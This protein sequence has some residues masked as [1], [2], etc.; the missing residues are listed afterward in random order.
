[1]KRKWREMK[2]RAGSHAGGWEGT[3]TGYREIMRYGKGGVNKRMTKISQKRKKVKK[4]ADK[5][6]N[7]VTQ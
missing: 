3:E 1:M 2:Q 4:G 7:T 5:M 6:I